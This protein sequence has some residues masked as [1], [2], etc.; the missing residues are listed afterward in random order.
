MWVVKLG[1]SLDGAGTIKNWADALADSDVPLVICPGGGAFAD[2]VRAAQS[3]WPIDDATAH[4]MAILAMEQTAHLLCGLRP[5]LRKVASLKTLLPLNRPDE[6]CFVWFPASDLINDPEIPSTWD[7][8]SDSLAAVLA[9]RIGADGLALV[10]SAPLP[11]VSTHVSSLQR[12]GLLDAAFD[13]FGSRC[14]CPVW[15]L[16]GEGAGEIHGLMRQGEGGRRV[17]FDSK[18]RALRRFL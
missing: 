18:K 5:S 17:L 9:R 3:R 8:T 15:L 6:G 10:K 1:G 16:P 14:G 11:E 12:V 2:Q 13:E 7:V 4:R